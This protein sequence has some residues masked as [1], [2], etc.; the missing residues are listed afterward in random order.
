MKKLKG[1]LMILLVMILALSNS[2]ECEAAWKSYSKGRWK[3][4]ISATTQKNKY[5]KNAWKKINGKYYYFDSNG[6]MKTGRTKIKG[7]WYYLDYNNG[8]ANNQ[9]KGSYYYGKDG[10]MVVKK[11]IGMYYVGKDGKKVPGKIKNTKDVR[12]LSAIT[13]LEAGNQSYEGKLAVANVV[14]NRVKDSRFPNTI[15]G[16]V[17]QNWQFTPAMNGSLNWLLN[18]G[19][20][21][22][23]DCVKAAK[24]AL[25]GR[26]NVRGYLYFTTGVWGPLQIGDHYFR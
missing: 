19:Q 20:T 17:Y 6:W 14:L 10:V 18:S 25:S 2:F 11:W 1:S 7:K 8:R 3:Y 23:S 15:E 22:Q 21:I 12:L 26:N 4:T 13:Y 5:I 24:E 16:V 9:W